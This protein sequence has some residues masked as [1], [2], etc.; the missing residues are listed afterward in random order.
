MGCQ[1]SK[2]EYLNDN[3][4]DRIEEP[5]LLKSYDSIKSLGNFSND[6]EVVKEINEGKLLCS[7]VEDMDRYFPRYILFKPELVTY[8]RK[9]RWGT[10]KYVC[11]DKRWDYLC[12]I[13]QR[14]SSNSCDN[15]LEFF[16]NKYS[17][18]QFKKKYIKDYCSQNEDIDELFI[19][20]NV[21]VAFHGN[22]I[23]QYVIYKKLQVKFD[24]YYIPISIY[25]TMKAK[26]DLMKTTQI[27]ELLGPKKIYVKADEDKRRS[28]SINMGVNTNVVDLSV[29]VNS[30]QEDEDHLG[31]G[32][33]YN[34]KSGFFFNIEELIEHIANV[35]HIFMSRE[36][37]EKD[38]ELRYL[39]RSRIRSF[40]KSYTRTLH[41]KKLSS[42]ETKMQVSL[43]NIYSKIGMNFK[44]NNE[45]CH[46]S[47]VIIHCKFFGVEEVALID[48]L[49]LDFEGFKIIL[50]KY[51][52]EKCSH[53]RLYTEV[54]FNKARKDIIKFVERVM[55]KADIR[56]VHND[57]I[58]STE[59]EKLE[60]SKIQEYID[61]YND[62]DQYSDI[63]NL[64]L[65]IR[66]DVNYTLL[67]ENGFNLI[68][69][70]HI[71]EYLHDVRIFTK[72]LLKHHKIEDQEDELFKE[73]P[74]EK[75]KDDIFMTFDN[76]KDLQKKIN[77]LLENPLTTSVNRAGY[78]ILN[79]KD[80]FNDSS[81]NYRQNMSIFLK[82]FIDKHKLNEGYYSLLE[83]VSHNKMKKLFENYDN[84]KYIQRN[85]NFYYKLKSIIEEEEHEKMRINDYNLKMSIHS[86]SDSESESI[87]IID[88]IEEPDT[89]FIEQLVHETIESAVNQLTKETKL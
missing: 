58:K 69:H 35:K 70:K 42:L 20:N 22:E 82:R 30:E 88:N 52:E 25:N 71:D 60:N 16:K 45:K 81:P 4:P 36:D 41:I 11:K 39:I 3:E 75:L 21:H 67:N 80:M 40:L 29:G 47:T 27:L 78:T 54:N 79:A 48:D 2:P 26:I 7:F 73:F 19:D 77:K 23:T 85:P 12:D 62:I 68:R 46:E 33:T 57:F 14:D 51:R 34:I 56:H 76:F 18:E 49:P 53:G 37:Y 84:I 32:T 89:N 43:S 6:G 44:Y 5:Q 61:M 55:D 1:M 63:K 13:V 24:F 50:D 83:Q 28:S 17:F 8:Y 9:N 15:Y 74:N 38:F 31:Q 86:K 64:I 10:K 59:E 66:S 72:R 65:L 87:I